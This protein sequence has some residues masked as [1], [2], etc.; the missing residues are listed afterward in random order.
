ML[1]FFK[2][3]RVQKA[4]TQLWDY[5]LNNDLAEHTYLYVNGQCWYVGQQQDP[6]AIMVRTKNNKFYYVETQIDVAQTL[7]T[8]SV[9]GISILLGEKF[10]D[11]I[12][13]VKTDMDIIL[14]RNKMKPLEGGSG[15][16][17]SDP[18]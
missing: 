6:T 16:L 8:Y 14:V 12:R 7:G 11:V 10:N 9:N 17:V 4:A 3:I 1:G 15:V 5:I 18:E 13:S 2:K